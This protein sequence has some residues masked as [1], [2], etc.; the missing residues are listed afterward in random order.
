MWNRRRVRSDQLRGELDGIYWPSHSRGFFSR[1]H[2]Q[3]DRRS[4]ASLSN[5]RSCKRRWWLPNH[6]HRLDIS[7]CRVQFDH[8]NAPCDVCRSE[9]ARR[10]SRHIRIPADHTIIATRENISVQTQ[11]DR[12][13]H[14]FAA[15]AV[16]CWVAGRNGGWQRADDSPR[17]QRDDLLGG[18]DTQWRRSRRAG[19]MYGISTTEVSRLRLPSAIV[20][21]VV[22][23]LAVCAFASRLR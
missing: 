22:H 4:R 18:D 9:L 7:R 12:N 16:C 19:L 5:G 15:Y 17:R 3:Y 11:A 20:E 6:I 2:I 23:R 21:C 8:G 1:W 10:G 13:R 14:A